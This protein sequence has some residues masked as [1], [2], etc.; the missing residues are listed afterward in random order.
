MEASTQPPT[1]GSAISV[2]N[3]SGRQVHIAQPSVARHRSQQELASLAAV[4]GIGFCS[5]LTNA[6]WRKN[7]ATAHSVAF[8]GFFRDIRHIPL[9]PEPWQMRYAGD[10]SFDHCEAA[11]TEAASAKIERVG[12]LNITRA[13][14]GHQRR[15]A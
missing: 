3:S 4:A 15:P 10:V 7:C 2:Q 11:E 8:D 9:E 13:R 12:V 5:P 14:Y 6:V 1:S